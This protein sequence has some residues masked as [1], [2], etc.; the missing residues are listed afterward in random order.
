VN[1]P[2]I[3]DLVFMRIVESAIGEGK[4]T[5]YDEKNATP[6]HRFHG[7]YAGR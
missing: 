4:T 6:N 1:R 2:D 3:E 5:Q 7:D